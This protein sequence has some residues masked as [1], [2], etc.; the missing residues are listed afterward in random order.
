MGIFS[1]IVG[2][3]LGYAAGM[4]MGDRPIRSM[5]RTADVARSRAQ[6]L[7][8]TAE[9]VRSRIGGVQDRTVDV[10]QVRDVMTTVPETVTSDASLREA[11][12]A[13]ERADV[14]DVLVV[15]GETLV[16][17]L[18]DRD[19]A[20][21]AVARGRDVSTTRVGDVF[22]SGAVSISPS[23]TVGEAIRLMREHDVR[24][25]PVVEQGRPVGVVGLADLAVSS[26]PTSLLAD[27]ATAPPNN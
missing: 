21:R 17:V 4:R 2:F 20:V 9:R 13:M 6:S 18:T 27:I 25:L 15:D 16:G 14:G 12:A 19:I 7:S 11:A 8:A 5:Q 23:E 22:S 24:R 26:E 1:G 3:G 10:R